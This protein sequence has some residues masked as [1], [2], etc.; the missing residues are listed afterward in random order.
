MDVQIILTLIFAV[1]M[2]LVALDFIRLFCVEL[3]ETC[4]KTQKI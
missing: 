2:A 4:Q 1:L 3:R